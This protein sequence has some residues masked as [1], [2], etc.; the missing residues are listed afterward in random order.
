M[1][2]N[3]Q[4]NNLLKEFELGDKLR[5]YKKL[6]KIFKENKQNNLLRYNLAVIQENLHLNKEARENYNY[7]IDTENNL[8]AMINLYNLD[9]RE[10]KFN[11]ALRIINKILKVNTIDN[12]YK[13]KAFVCL[14]LHKF[15]EAKKICA[16]YLNKNDKDIST[17]II[18]GQCFFDEGNLD[19]AKKIF[20]DIVVIDNNNLSALN[21]LGRIYHTKR[22]VVKAEKF[23]L[24]ALAI[25]GKSYHILNN[26]AGLYRESGKYNEALDYYN[27]ALILNPNNAYIYNNL[28]KTYFDLNNHDDAKKNSFKALELK[29]EDG[30]IQK[31][32]SFIYLKDFDFINGWN[33][34]EGRLNLDDFLE[35]NISIEKLNKKIFRKKSI[36]N[37]NSKFLIVREQGVGDEILYGSMYGDLLEQIKNV[38]IECDKRLIKL[39]KR[40]FPRHKTKFLKLGSISNDNEKLKKVDHVLYAG[41]L[42]RFYRNDINSFSGKQYLKI[43]DKKFKEIK[44][45]LLKFKS[46]Y[47]I[48]ISWKSFNNK[49]SSDKSL[50]LSDFKH[51]FN[52]PNT[53]IINLQYGD[54]KEEVNK[55]NNI[56]KNKILSFEN[57]DLFNDFEGISCLLKS[58]DLF[59]SV[60]NSTAHLAGSLGVKT[61]LIKPDNYALFHYWNQKNNF[62]PWYNSVRLIDKNKFF[63]ELNTIDKIFS[64]LD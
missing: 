22:E 2:L 53:N 19:K 21:S 18:L 9:I 5:A 57:I 7:L 60:S 35:K 6:Q 43:D 39:F 52:L 31:A 61:L 46:K 63:K 36:K 42:G 38:S 33:Y 16:Y 34:F 3:F 40:S 59:I 24:K 27:R 41:S 26:I 37:I 47:K 25:N 17:L 56:T 55:F 32:L 48:G 45:Q 64:Y 44:A 29:K 10:V 62:T 13:D 11:E 51:I 20:N 54:I 50:N 14:K 1:N 23:F 58:L 4:I 30:D 8:K 15:E 28:A 12:V 49:Y